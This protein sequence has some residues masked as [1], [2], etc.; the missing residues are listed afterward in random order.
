MAAAVG[1][2]IQLVSFWSGQKGIEGAWVPNT[3]G[4]IN[5]EHGCPGQVGF[6]SVQT[7]EKWQVQRY[8]NFWSFEALCSWF[9]PKPLQTLFHKS[10]EY[11]SCS[12]NLN[13][14]C[15]FG[16]VEG[17]SSKRSHVHAGPSQEYGG[18]PRN[19][20]DMATWPCWRR[21]GPAMLRCVHLCSESCQRV[22][23][24][25]PSAQ[26]IL[27]GCFFFVSWIHV[28]KTFAVKLHL[29]FQ[30]NSRACI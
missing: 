20:P 5:F 22:P 13:K 6:R 1:H 10:A 9:V 2:E 18:T 23:F 12:D 21:Y 3:K 7:I 29:L 19:K 4:A 11:E 16:R 26:R 14:G 17:C 28:F 30:L 24:L 25:M 8:P 27:T 15:P